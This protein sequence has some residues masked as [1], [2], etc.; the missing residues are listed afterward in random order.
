MGTFVVG[1]GS[2]F[3]DSDGQF[4]LPS[5]RT[6]FLDLP[7][8]V[9]LVTVPVPGGPITP[10][11]T[12]GIDAFVMSGG[13]LGAA[14]LADDERLAIVCRWG[15]GYD[16][17]NLDECA[18]HGVVVTNA[19]EGV[20]RSMAQTAMTFVLMLAHRIV[21]QDRAIRNGNVWATKHQFIGTGL[22]GKTLGVIGLGNIGREILRVASVFD[23]EVIGFDPYADPA[24]CGPVT[25]VE[26]DDLMAR[27]DFII[28]QCALTPE[29]R[30]MI[31]RERL[32]LM[33]PT[34]Y[35]VNTARGPIVDEV[36]LIEALTS[37]RI[38]GAA[39]DVFAKE[40]LD[41]DNP[42]IQLDNVILTPHSA[43]WTDDFAR[44]T[45]MSVS[46]S[47]RSI[48]AGELPAN[49]VNRRELAEA[50]VVPRYLRRHAA[51]T[52]M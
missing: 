10:E 51:A 29:T 15:V 47:I 52:T 43:G 22:V 34:A 31:S 27:S 33:K 28:I 16:T 1:I 6:S 7:E 44:Q 18:A 42:L 5:L 32:A 39:L 25:L 26:L 40:P 21:D 13:S 41:D 11:T 14:S 9:E 35:L 30:G 3:Y 12:T 45:A 36:A 17:V 8:G 24:T 20:R 38:A 23:C 48:I 37:R 46:G 4:R 19:P 2:D 50:G 49:C